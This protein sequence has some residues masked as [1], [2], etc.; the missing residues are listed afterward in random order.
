MDTEPAT[1]IHSLILAVNSAAID[2]YWI[3]RYEF[4]MHHADPEHVFGVGASDSP[5]ELTISN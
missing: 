5:T 1:N 2:L 4:C 3:F